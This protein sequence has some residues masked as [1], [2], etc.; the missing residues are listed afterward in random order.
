MWEYEHSVETTATREAIWGLWTDVADR[1]SWNS[2]IETIELRGPF[3]EGSTISMTP[4]GQDT[5]L[6][7]LTDV[8]ENELFVDEAKVAELVL[9]TIHRLDQLDP[10]RVRI[11][12]RMEITGPAADETGPQLG[13]QITADFPATI[14]A[15]IERA[16]R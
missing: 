15:L 2:D 8:R 9:R 4:V 14:A 11:T 7:H 1:G 10:D 12:Y 6:L 3:A 5:V 16:T 13:P